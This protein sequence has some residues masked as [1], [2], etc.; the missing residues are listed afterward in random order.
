MKPAWK[1]EAVL[2]RRRWPELCFLLLLSVC[3]GLYRTLGR[4]EMTAMRMLT[5]QQFALLP[6]WGL[7][8]TVFRDR[9]GRLSYRKSVLSGHTRN[10]VFAAK[11]AFYLLLSL[12]LDALGCCVALGSQGCFSPAVLPLLLLRLGLD[13][14]YAAA[15]LL[16]AQFP[17]PNAATR[18]ILCGGSALALGLLGGMSLIPLVFS[19][20]LLLVCPALAWSFIRRCEL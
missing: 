19:V 12:L 15:P 18:H 10:S 6:C 16:L 20:L 9:Q 17:F 4:G 14:G 7:A 2:L 8:E 5:N 3:V 1:T 11:L 13:L